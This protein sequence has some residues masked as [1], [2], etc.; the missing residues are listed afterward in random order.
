M[1]HNTTLLVRWRS[2]NGDMEV[3]S[4]GYRFSWILQINFELRAGCYAGNASFGVIA[5]FQSEV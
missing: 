4:R 1:S 3:E 5:R 2:D